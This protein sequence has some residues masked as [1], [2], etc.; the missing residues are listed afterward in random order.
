M[1]TYKD[2][3]KESYDLSYINYDDTI[4]SY[5]KELEKCIHK[6]ELYPLYENDYLSEWENDVEHWSMGQYKKEIKEEMEREGMIEE[7][8]AHEEDIEEWIMDHNEKSS[9]YEALK[10]TGEMTM[11]YTLN[12]NICVEDEE[13]EEVQIERIMHL[14]GVEEG[15][16]KNVKSLL[17]N[18]MYDGDLRIYFNAKPIDMIET[19]GKSI[20][21]FGTVHVGIINTNV[22]AGDVEEIEL[23]VTLPFERENIYLDTKEKWGWREISGAYDGWARETDYE[24]LDEESKVDIEVNEEQKRKMEWEEKC[25]RRFREGECTFGDMDIKRHRDVVYINK[26]PCGSKC[27]HCGTFWID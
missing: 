25:E 12:E 24:I 23:D 11:F 3:L 5:T 1:K 7:Y 6:G 16:R 21:F 4:E 17:G 8:E 15:S 19:E 13:M 18:A 14:L 2:F 10:N 26:Y 22:G 9:I 27:P 20:R